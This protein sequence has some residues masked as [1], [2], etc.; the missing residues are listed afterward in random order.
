M[1]Y[2]NLLLGEVL[3]DLKEFFLCNC[4]TSI[5]VH[6]L[7]H[8]ERLQDHPQKYLTFVFP[9]VS[10]TFDPQNNQHLLKGSLLPQKLSKG[11]SAIVVPVHPFEKVL[12]FRPGKKSIGKKGHLTKIIEEM[13]QEIVQQ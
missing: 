2:C 12:N 8:L 9:I 6:T 10:Q 11:E 3:T 13:H 5:L 4:S 1:I 7:E